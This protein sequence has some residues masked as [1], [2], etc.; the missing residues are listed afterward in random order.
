M[1]KVGEQAMQGKQMPM[2]NSCMTIGAL[3]MK[4][5]K[6]ERVETKNG[7]IWIITSDDPELVEGVQQW[8]KK[9]MHEVAK[10]H[11]GEKS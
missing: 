1:A 3:M 7:E 9:N 11:G 4:G 5:L 6:S 10:M 2:C 8:A